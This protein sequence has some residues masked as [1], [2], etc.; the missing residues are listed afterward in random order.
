MRGFWSR[1]GLT[2]CLMGEAGMT[3]KQPSQLQSQIMAGMRYWRDQIGAECP[4]FSFTLPQDRLPFISH[5]DDM[6]FKPQPYVTAHRDAVAHFNDSPCHRV[7]YG[8]EEM[9]L[10]PEWN[11]VM[12]CRNDV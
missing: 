7:S 12:E 4:S 3:P 10:C 2:K 8:K 5:E 11:L 6:D 1:T 9:V